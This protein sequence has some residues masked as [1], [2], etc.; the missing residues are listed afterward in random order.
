[1][2][3]KINTAP[4][5][6]NNIVLVWMQIEA[7]YIFTHNDPNK[8]TNSTVTGMCAHFKLAPRSVGLSGIYKHNPDLGG[9]NVHQMKSVK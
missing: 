1:M 3:E 5:K 9:F 7:S 8:Y 6:N 2:K 4:P